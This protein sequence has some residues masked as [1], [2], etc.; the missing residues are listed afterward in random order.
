VHF[1]VIVQNKEISKS[2]I[3]YLFNTITCFDSSYQPSSG[4]EWIGA[5]CFLR[6]KKKVNIYL[7]INNVMTSPKISRIEIWRIKLATVNMLNICSYPITNT[8]LLHYFNSCTVRLLLFC[9]M[10]QQMYKLCICWFVVQNN[11]R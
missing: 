3:F 4:R 8:T 10:S 1:L 6:I 2:C 5:L 11:K 7:L 9:T